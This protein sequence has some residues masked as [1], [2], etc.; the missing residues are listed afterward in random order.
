MKPL[1][2]V[3]AFILLACGGSKPARSDDSSFGST[4]VL[5][6]P[7]ATPWPWSLWGTLWITATGQIYLVPK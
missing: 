4:P 6:H 1:A 7:I 2:V 3:L 5:S